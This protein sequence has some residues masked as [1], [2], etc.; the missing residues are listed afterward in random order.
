M[1]IKRSY[2][3]FCFA[4]NLA[5]QLERQQAAKKQPFNQKAAL[6]LSDSY[7]S[8]SRCRG[9]MQAPPL[10]RALRLRP[11]ELHQ[12]PEHPG[13]RPLQDHHHRQFTAGLRL[14]GVLRAP[15]ASVRYTGRRTSTPLGSLTVDIER[16][17]GM[18]AQQSSWSL[19]FQQ[20]MEPVQRW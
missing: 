3:G 6:P 2:R 18:L 17:F 12:G 15:P 1:G 13:Q 16:T 9:T 19:V 4:V 20:M 8:V 11:G 14:P 7:L 5:K 10:P